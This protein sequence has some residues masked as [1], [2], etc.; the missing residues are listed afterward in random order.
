MRGMRRIMGLLRGLAGVLTVLLLLVS[1]VPAHAQAVVAQ[2]MRDVTYAGSGGVTLAG[3]L[4]IPSHPAGTRVPGVIIVAGSGPVDRDGNAAQLGVNTTLYSQIADQ[5]AQVGIASLRYDKRAVGGST[6]LPLP[7]DL[8]HPTAAEIAAIQNFV[9]WDNYVNDA[10]ATLSYLQQQPE[11]DPARTALIGHSE[12]AY[13]SEVVATTSQGLIHSPAALVLIS[14]PGRP[15]DTVLR[16]QVGKVLQQLQ[17]TPDVTAFVLNTFDTVVA[18]IK[19]TGSVPT[20][21]LVALQQNSQVPTPVTQ[22]ILSLFTPINN[23]FWHGALQVDPAALVA[24]YPSPVLVLQGAQD[25]Q[26]FPTEDAPALDAALQRRTP[27]DHE[28]YIV[29]N[30]SHNM[31]FVRDPT[32]DAG[33][34]G[35]IVPE[36]A[37]KLRTWLSAKLVIAPTPGMP[38]TGQADQPDLLAAL[39]GLGGLLLGLGWHLRR[40]RATYLAFKPGTGE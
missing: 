36:A 3:T 12:G 17:T 26:V 11:I 13:L 4:V 6:P 20:A 30:A 23:A 33:V 35:P 22:L 1:T 5:L 9:A 24:R 16:E 39:L 19:E 2:T 29:P 27:D 14:G 32:T 25:V 31:K 34:V 37:D 38:R 21:A 28:L 10:A 40:P 7:K 8:Q 18:G 15:Y